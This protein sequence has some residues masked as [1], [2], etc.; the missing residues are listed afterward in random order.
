ML[1]IGGADARLRE[2]T[3][4]AVAA[5]NFFGDR[6]CFLRELADALLRREN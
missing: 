1:G 2:K 3:D 6:A 5:L 4:A